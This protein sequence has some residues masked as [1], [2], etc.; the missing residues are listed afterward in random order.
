[1]KNILVVTLLFHV[2]ESIVYYVVPDDKINSSSG[3]TGGFTL[4]HYLNNTDKYFNSQTEF[5]FNQGHHSLYKEWIL[6]NVS[7]FI[8]NGNNNTL[9]CLKPSLGIGVINVIN[10]TIKNLHI[11]QCSKNW[12]Y[13]INNQT[14]KSRYIPTLIK[15]AIYIYHSADVVISNTFITVTVDDSNTSGIIGINIFTRNLNTSSVTNTTVLLLCENNTYNLTSGIVMVYYDDGS[16]SSSISRTMLTIQQYNYKTCGLYKISFALALIMMQ[17]EYNVTIQVNDT[18]FSDLLNSSALFYYAKTCRNP[19]KQSFLLFSN[20]KVENNKG[21][22]LIDLFHIEIHSHDHIFNIAKSEYLCS[23]LANLITF[24]NC[25]FINNT[26][27]G[28]LINILLKHN[29]QMNVFVEIRNSSIC[30]NNKLQFINTDSELK[31]LKTLSHTITVSATNILCNSCAAK[32]RMS[33][34]SLTSG[35]IK[36]EDSVIA[37]NMNFKSIVQL[38]SS[39]L[40]FE[41]FTNFSGNYAR[42][43]LKGTEGS[44]YVHTEFSKVHFNDNFVY[45]LSQT[46]ITYTKSLQQICVN[47]FITKSKNNLDYK[48]ENGAKLNF[49]VI[50]GSNIYISPKYEMYFLSNETHYSNCVWLA[51]TAFQTK[52]SRDIL[53][54]IFNI[55]RTF[56]SRVDIGKIPSSVCPCSSTDDYNCSQH[57]IGSVYPGQRLTVNLII[58]EISR[59]KEYMTMIAKRY[60]SSEAGCEIQRVYELTQSRLSH[61]CNNYYYTIWYGGNSSVC[62][63]YLGTEDIPE[64]FYVNLIPCPVGFS[65]QENRKGCYCDQILNTEDV[66]KITSCNLKDGTVER[67]AN[68]WI[69]GQVI[70]N[71][72]TYT[73]CTNCPFDYC[74]PHSS[75][76]NLSNPDSQCQFDRSGLLC[77]HCPNGFSAVLGSSQCMQCSNITL[78][79]ILPIAMAGILLVMMLFIS[80]LTVMNGTINTFIFYFNIVSINI[81]AFISRSDN[82]FTFITLS[83]FNLDLGIKTCFYDGMDSYTKTWLQLV[84]P[85]YLIFIALT[86][87]MGSRYSKIVQRV[88]A[89]KGL[90]VLATLFLL[91]Y[92]KFLLTVCHAIF[93]Y[94]TVIHLPSEDSTL[95]WSVD[96][97]IPLFGVKFTILFVTCL[98]IFLILLPFNILLLCTRSLMRFTFINTFKPLLDTYFGPYKDKF[99]YWTG[100]QLLLRAI[101]FGLSTLDPNT[102]LIGGGIMLG[103]LLCF[104]CFVRPFKGWLK[105]VQECIIL[106]NLQV[107]YIATLYN[108]TDSKEKLPVAWCL[109]FPL[110]IYFI[111]FI[112]CHCLMSLCGRKVK[113]QGYYTISALRNKMFN[114]KWSCKP[115]DME[116]INTIPDYEKFQESLIALNN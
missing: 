60:N 20:C 94:S 109:V 102:N 18:N 4:Q 65:L 25:N 113:Q 72:N 110:L 59:S 66:I 53:K 112:I 73:V 90:A 10:I 7:D 98:V 79:V 87:I 3:N 36:F 11:K 12:Y 83:L 29:E 55:E 97:N 77:G 51:S 21:N 58:P 44:Y 49:T 96:T 16:K 19:Y 9:N 57:E 1:M 75:Y 15:S 30:F 91:S 34:I 88:T 76:I 13:T 33:L 27:M 68:S 63:L 41:G 103:I 108:D 37:N 82:P 71:V 95:V 67:P 86:L 89:R 50:Q 2:T 56:A 32:D 92:T 35:M 48:F 14:Y 42:Y 61:K 40:Q 70:N 45:T 28:S 111:I 101:F 99:Y 24:K 106:L 8:I 5:Q 52:N 80:N 62:E 85:V 81:S 64:I 104:Q 93:F 107:L 116:S 115:T 6:Q 17:K 100:L 39:L 105:N 84:F 47:Q 46:S 43:I 74:I 114:I 31:L 38:H 26:N 78:L 69:S 23:K 54:K 22:G